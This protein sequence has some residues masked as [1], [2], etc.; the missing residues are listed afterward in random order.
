MIFIN[1]KY[2][3]WYYSIINSAK[4]RG[5]TNKAQAKLALGYIENHH[6]IPKSIGGSDSKD[7]LVYLT[8][9]EHF[10]CHW[11]LVKMTSR[12]NYKKMVFALVSMSRKAKH[13]HRYNTR[14]TS[15]V[16]NHYKTISAN[17]KKELY[18]GRARN[19][20]IY[21]F[22][23][24]DGRIEYSTILAMS[25]KYNILRSS[26][27]HLIK[28]PPGKHHAKGWSLEFP[29]TSSSRSELYKGSGGPTYDH[30]IYTFNHITGITELC[31]KYE[32]FVKYNL[33]RNGVYAICDGTQKSSQG[34]HIVHKSGN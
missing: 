31:T 33:S 3:T 28:K 17:I 25:K 15:K 30:T 1:N 2:T 16:Y 11:L 34:W 32:L 27:G 20:T 29:M 9:R 5:F 8:G 14:I 13:Q 18:T 22:C 26:I 21:K 10:I 6:I 23:H 24:V 12:L 7:N 4:A 19:T